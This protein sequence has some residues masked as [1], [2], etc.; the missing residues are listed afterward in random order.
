MPAHASS[1]S[2]LI[3]AVGATL[4]YG[5]GRY[6]WYNVIYPPSK[7]GVSSPFPQPSRNVALTNAFPSQYGKGAP[8][9][10]T[11]VRKAYGP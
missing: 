10:M 6:L 7:S 2:L 1:L 11:S 4:V 8:G 5:V 3:Y 9:F